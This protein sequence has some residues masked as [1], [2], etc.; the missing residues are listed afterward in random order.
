MDLIQVVRGPGNCRAPEGVMIGRA[1]I[2]VLTRTSTAKHTGRGRGTLEPASQRK[3]RPK[4]PGFLASCNL[5][6][7][8]LLILVTNGEVGLGALQGRVTRAQT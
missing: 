1:V 3:T 6:Q 2:T 7:R 8:T 5:T 4:M